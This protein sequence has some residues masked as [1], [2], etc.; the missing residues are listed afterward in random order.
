[1]NC[2]LRRGMF[3]ADWPYNELNQAVSWRI[4]AH[5]AKTFEASPTL[6]LLYRSWMRTHALEAVRKA[7][8]IKVA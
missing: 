3:Y 1:M 4:A 8:A 6:I 5:A 2:K 7:R